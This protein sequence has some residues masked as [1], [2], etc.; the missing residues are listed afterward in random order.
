[1]IHKVGNTDGKKASPLSTDDIV[2][3]IYTTKARSHSAEI[4]P[5]II[6]SIKKKFLR[7]M[8]DIPPSS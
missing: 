8:D 3:P 4:P 1:A 2:I 5:S 7:I 6:N